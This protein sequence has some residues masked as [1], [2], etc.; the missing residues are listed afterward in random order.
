MATVIQR[1]LSGARSMGKRISGLWLSKLSRTPEIPESRVLPADLFREIANHLTK[2]DILVLSSCSSE[3]R[4]LLLPEIYATV[5]G[6]CGSRACSERLEM[7]SA[8]PKRW[9]YIR[10]LEIA[11]D[12]RSWPIEESVELRV[13]STL[14]K[15][16][17]GLTNLE[18]FTWGSRYPLQETVWR[19]LRTSCPNLRNLTYTTQIR[20]FQPDSELFKLRSLRQFSLC[21][22]DNAQ[23]PPAIQLDLPPQLCD[24]VLQNS[25]LE[26][27]FLR[28]CSS[29]NNL[30]SLSPLMQGTWSKLQSFHIEIC[31][32]H[33][34]SDA[35]AAFL[36]LHPSIKSLSL[37]PHLPQI[38]P[39]SL[40]PDTLPHLESFTGIS[41]HVA[42]LPHVDHLESLVLADSPITDP[43]GVHTALGRLTSLTS[44]SVTIANAGDIST[45][46]GIV[47]VCSILQSLN[48]SYQTPCTTKQLK[49]IAVELKRLPLLR[50][51]TLSKTYRVADG[52][53]LAAVLVLLEY[54]PG[55]REINKVWEA[56]KGWKQRG[57]YTI[58]SSLSH[59]KPIPKFVDAEEFGPRALGGSFTRRF[60]YPL[61]GGDNVS[62]G[63]A[64]IRR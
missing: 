8:T 61:D 44:L 59:D 29:H 46:S 9:V 56:T 12:W 33:P 22:P 63:L 54:N 60:R 39:L 13:A 10:K 50:N 42:A 37:F 4:S 26:D 19:A 64:R 30:Q 27:L 6:L 28:V 14:E 35:I 58:T 49:A 18:T 36:A 43:S 5:S 41:Q 20:E 16:F 38:L 7:L 40:S 15:I 51:F 48:V 3:L 2:Q 21:V 24:M 25:D 34:A 62:K 31:S 1:R 47:S 45:L 53:M 11:L 17:P 23:A 52:T 57:H 32:H 55:L